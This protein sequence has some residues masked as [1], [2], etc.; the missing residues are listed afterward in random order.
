MTTRQVV[1]ALCPHCG[2][3]FMAS[4]DNILDVGSDPSAKV[5]LLQGQV[6]VTQCPQCG[7]QAAMKAP[8]FYHDPEKQLA[9]AYVPNELGLHNN[10]QQK[11]IGDM[12]NALLNTLPAEQRKGYLLTPQI[13]I[14]LQRMLEE[15]LKS[16]GITPEMLAKQKSQAQLLDKLIRATNEEMLRTLV[17]ENEADLD[18]DFF[19]LMTASARAAYAEGQ[20]EATQAMLALRNLIAEMAPNGSDIISQVNAE[21]GFGETLTREKLLDMLLTTDSEEEFES[22]IAAGRSLLDYPFFQDLTKRIEDAGE[23][24]E[25][26]QLKDLRTRILDTS[27]RQDEEARQT[28]EKSA[29]LLKLLLQAKDPR[30]V[31]KQHLD[32][33]DDAFFSVLT[34]NIQQ[35]RSQKQEDVAKRLEQLGAMVLQVVEEN[36]PPE[37][38]LLNQL[39]QAKYPEGTQQLID[40]NREII[41]ESFVAAIDQLADQMEKANQPDITTHL[42]QVARQAGQFAPRAEHS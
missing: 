38:R 40:A 9:M 8:L 41:T 24:E 28:I 4:L 20:V 13:F 3:R 6:N 16:D 22:L 1:P 21:L 5:R 34:A 36:M 39:I 11:I 25:G 30:E 19:R 33:I 12:S 10:D 15:I 35:A 32:E 29:N 14:N 31:A 17:E 18:Y 37:V 42:R 27:A 23:S 7:Q 2:S 26:T